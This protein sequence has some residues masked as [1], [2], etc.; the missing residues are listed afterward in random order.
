MQYIHYFP[1][2]AAYE[3]ARNNEYREPWVSYTDGKGLDYNYRD[4]NVY[5]DMGLPSGKLWAACNIGANNPGEVG[6][7]FDWGAVTPETATTL[8]TSNLPIFLD[9]SHD[10]AT[11]NMGSDWHMPT[12]ADVDELKEN[13][14]RLE[15]YNTNPYIID[16]TKIFVSPVNGNLLYMTDCEDGDNYCGYETWTAERCTLNYDDEIYVIYNEDLSA[17]LWVYDSQYMGIRAV[18]DK[19][20]GKV[21]QAITIDDLLGYPFKCYDANNDI[22]FESLEDFYEACEEGVTTC[23]FVFN[24]SDFNPNTVYCTFLTLARYDGENI[25]DMY[26]NLEGEQLTVPGHPGLVYYEALG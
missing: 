24:A 2:Q 21:E 22:L 11:V 23:S 6:S 25:M 26:S 8:D 15:I 14:I 1:N 19:T 4:G 17:F 3:Y 10:A 16:Y 9:A 13:V 7:L 5:V 20:R 12:K 18:T